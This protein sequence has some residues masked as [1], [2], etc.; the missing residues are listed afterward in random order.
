MELKLY[1]KPDEIEVGIDEVGRGCLFGPVYSAAV[2][3]PKTFHN[4]IYK[5]IKDSKQLSSKKRDYFAEYIKGIA[6]DYSVGIVDNNIVD[7]LNILGATMKSMHLALDDLSLSVDRI[8]V[9]GDKFKQ[10]LDN[11]GN[12]ISHTCIPKGDNTFLSIACASII[13]KT[14]RDKY[15][16]DLVKKNPTLEKYGLITN[17]GYGTKQHINAIKINGITKWHRVSFSPCS[18]YSNSINK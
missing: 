11:N 18:Q 1:N 7:D 12:F 15:I 2:I 10:Y 16:C 4:D 13:A 14:A 17:K 8:L 5:G 3:L 9:D 6:I